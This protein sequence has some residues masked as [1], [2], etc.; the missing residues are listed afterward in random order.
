M[1]MHE[2]V[3]LHGAHGVVASHPLRMRKALGSIPSVSTFALVLFFDQLWKETLQH[4]VSDGG[5]SLWGGGGWVG[6]GWSSASVW[7]SCV[8]ACDV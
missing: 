4:I 1:D 6:A 8:R 5:G 2:Q 3:C 7:L